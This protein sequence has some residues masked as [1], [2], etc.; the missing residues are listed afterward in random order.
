MTQNNSLFF[1]EDFTLAVQNHTACRDCGYSF[2]H[3]LLQSISLR[4]SIHSYTGLIWP[5]SHIS[6]FLYGVMEHYAHKGNRSQFIFSSLC[7]LSNK[8]ALSVY[9]RHLALFYFILFYFSLSK[10]FVTES[11][12]VKQDWQ[13]YRAVRIWKLADVCLP[14]TAG[15]GL[16]R[17]WKVMGLRELFL[18]HL[19][20][21]ITR[22]FPSSFLS[23]LSPAQWV[24]RYILF[25]KHRERNKSTELGFT[26]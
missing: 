3:S 19:T 7:P 4:F 23:V 11:S 9:H 13:V 24:I 10:Q 18:I 12:D 5:I 2:T 8:F 1:L 22:T 26:R 16:Q 21:K 15:I 17:L 20:G 14:L 25:T 6:C